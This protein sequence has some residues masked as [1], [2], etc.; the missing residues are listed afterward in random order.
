[1]REWT[2]TQHLTF[3]LTMALIVGAIVYCIDPTQ[4]TL[5]PCLFHSLTGLS[6]A[7]CGMTRAAHC[8]MHGQWQQAWQWNPLAYA[9]LPLMVF[10]FLQRAA[11]WLGW[12]T[13]RFPFRSQPLQIFSLI[14][15][16][17][18]MVWRNLR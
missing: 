6:C 7:G 18:F 12:S 17:I 5:V 9:V 15:V 14:A 16:L 11:R 10:H 2:E 3:L 1:M 8:M 4:H 13:S